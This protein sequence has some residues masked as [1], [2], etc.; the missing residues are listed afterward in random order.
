VWRGCLL[1]GLRLYTVQLYRA[2]AAA[3]G[4]AAAAAC[5]PW[6]AVALSFVQNQA[7]GYVHLNDLRSLYWKIVPFLHRLIQLLG[8]AVLSMLMLDHWMDTGWASPRWLGQ[9]SMHRLGQKQSPVLI[10]YHEWDSKKTSVSRQSAESDSFISEL[11]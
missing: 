4:A 5:S 2:E 3:R 1:C 8:V 9:D 7:P 10:E 11:Y 6:C